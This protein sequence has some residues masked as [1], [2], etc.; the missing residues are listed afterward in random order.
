[1][2]GPLVEVI[3]VAL[4]HLDELE[5]AD[6]DLVHQRRHEVGGIQRA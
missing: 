6:E 3:D 5:I 1:M 2:Q 4:D